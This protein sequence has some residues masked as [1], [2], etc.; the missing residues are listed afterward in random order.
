MMWLGRVRGRARGLNERER[1]ATLKGHYEKS[2][3]ITAGTA[4][5][6]IKEAPGT[7]AIGCS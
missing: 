1:K 5:V 6:D 3:V 7:E 2:T 4:N